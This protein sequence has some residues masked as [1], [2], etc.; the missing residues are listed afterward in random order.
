MF[1]SPTIAPVR[2]P[3]TDVRHRPFFLRPFLDK[4]TWKSSLYLLMSLPLGIAWFT[5]AITLLS[6]SAGL[7]VTVIGIPLMIATVW[8]GRAIAAA[9]RARAAALLDIDVRPYPRRAPTSTGLWARVG[10]GLG[11]RGGWQGLLYGFLM[12]PWGIT[13]FVVTITLWSVALGGATAPIW[14]WLVDQQFGED[15]VLKGWGRLGWIAGNFVLGLVLLYVTPFIVRGFAAVDK[16]LVRGLLSQN[17]KEQLTKRVEELTV[18]RDASVEGSQ[19]ELRRLERDLHDGAQQRLVALAMDLGMAKER[20][21][22]TDQTEAAE[23]VGRAHEEAK[24]AI[25]E[26]RNLVRGIMPSVLTDRGLDAALSALAGR[27]AIPIEV[28]VR[29]DERPPATVESAAYFV[30]AEALTNVAKHSRASYA[31]VLVTRHQNAL[32]IAVTDDGI[33]GAHEHAG[34]GLAGLHDRVRSVEGSLR[35]T[36]PPGGPTTLVVDIPCAS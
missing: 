14:G 19:G 29:L 30:V 15:Y 20:L 22:A 32:R 9:D 11:D 28:D 35:M 16:A 7:F 6:V 26:L 10:A 2:G 5:I 4:R 31:S 8:I 12:L 33:G 18:S 25:G 13:T 23:L 27:S 3:R 24:N 21:A 1:A 34:G 36:S 17:E